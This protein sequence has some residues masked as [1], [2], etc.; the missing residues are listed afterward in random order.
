[1]LLHFLLPL[2]LQLSLYLLVTTK[3]LLLVLILLLPH[4]LLLLLLLICFNYYYTYFASS[5]TTAAT[6][7]AYD[8]SVITNASTASCTF[9]KSGGK[10]TTCGFLFLS[11]PTTFATVDIDGARKLIFALPGNI[12]MSQVIGHVLFGCQ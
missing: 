1:M 5:S 6:T 12:F 4:Q 8:Y 10:L 2:L 7:I 3:V 9:M 11:L